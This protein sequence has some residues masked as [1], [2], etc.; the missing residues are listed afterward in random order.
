[1]TFAILVLLPAHTF[2]R[3]C[4]VRQCPVLQC[5]VLQF[6]R[7]RILHAEDV[8]KNHRIVSPQPSAEYRTATELSSPT[9]SRLQ[10]IRW[11]SK[12]S[13]KCIIIVRL[14]APYDD[15]IHAAFILIN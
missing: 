13:P 10:P 8:M 3:H 9:L 12:H 7:S 11:R 4:P 2:V 5:P 15:T 14:H 6:Q 1:M